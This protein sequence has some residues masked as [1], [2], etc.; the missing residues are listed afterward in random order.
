MKYALGNFLLAFAWVALTGN[1]SLENIIIGYIIGLALLSTVPQTRSEG[2]YF[3]RLWKLFL[4]VGY[5]I[6]EVL[7]ANVKMLGF[8][9]S[10]NERMRPGIVIIPLDIRS[11][12]GVT[13]LANI[14]TLTPGTLTMDVAE[15]YSYLVMHSIDISDPD[16]ARREIK[17]GFE[18]RLME[19]LE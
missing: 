3:A 14:I 6:K 9:L 13:L 5:F 4:F 10:R 11:T 18:R 2:R 7:I 19:I 15:N 1:V 8:I 12:I 17:E 16:T